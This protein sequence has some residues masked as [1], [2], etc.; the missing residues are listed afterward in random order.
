MQTH[1]RSTPQYILTNVLLYPQSQNI[2]VEHILVG[3]KKKAFHD[4][5]AG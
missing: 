5:P 2:Y 1:V 3:K 4:S